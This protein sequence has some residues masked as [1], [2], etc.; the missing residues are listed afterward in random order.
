MG[1]NLHGTVQC[2]LNCEYFVSKNERKRKKERRNGFAKNGET[3]LD[4]L[5]ESFF[6]VQNH[7]DSGFLSVDIARAL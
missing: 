4:N 7:L 5:L 3:I 2:V 1:V 6:K